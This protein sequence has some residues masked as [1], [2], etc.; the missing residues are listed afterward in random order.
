MR[1]VDDALSSRYFA[2]VASLGLVL[3]G[4]GPPF[5]AS[6]LAVGWETSDV[7]FVSTLDPIGRAG[8]S[9]PY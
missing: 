3:V 6:L 4:A 7:A 2:A 1:F 9:S 8:L 5:G